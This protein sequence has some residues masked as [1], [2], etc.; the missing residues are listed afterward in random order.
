MPINMRNSPNIRIKV[1]KSH[2]FFG[3]IFHFFQELSGFLH[4][5][6]VFFVYYESWCC[7]PRPAD[8]T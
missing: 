1:S 7:F 8:Y 3:D 6:P 5:S 2:R 4:V